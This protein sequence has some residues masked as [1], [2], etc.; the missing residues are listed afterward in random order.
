MKKLLLAMTAIASLAFISKAATLE[1][2]TGTSFESF[3]VDTALDISADDN[4][5]PN[6]TKYWLY[7]GA[8]GTEETPVDTGCVIKTVDYTDAETGYA[9]TKPAIAP[10]TDVKALGIEADKRL[11]RTIT[12]VNGNPV[13]IGSGI[14]FDTMVQFTA[15][16]TAPTP[17][18][19]DK[20]IV[21]L[22]G[23]DDAE[24]LFGATTGLVVTAGYL[25]SVEN[26][27]ISTNYFV[28]T[29]IE[30]N[31]WHRL[32][33]K[34]LDKISNES[35]SAPAGFVV[36]I[37]EVAVTSTEAKGVADSAVASLT[38]TA[39]K[40]AGTNQL[41]PSLVKGGATAASTLTAVDIEGT[42]MIDNISFTSVAPNFAVDNPTLVINWGDGITSVTYKIGEADAVTATSG[43]EITLEKASSEVTINA[44][45]ASGYVRGTWLLNGVATELATFTISAPT[46]IE[47]VAKAELIQV[48]D[49]TFGSAADL[50]T[51]LNK[52]ASYIG[53]VQLLGDLKIGHDVSEGEG[54][55]DLISVAEGSDITLDLAGKTITL[56]NASASA[57]VANLGG[58][59]TI[60]NSTEAIGRI[61]AQVG[62]EET[63]AY[64]VF[65]A[66]GTTTIAGGIFDGTVIVGAPDGEGGVIDTGATL[67]I[68]GGSF[69]STDSV[70]FYLT[71]YVNT[72]EGYNCTYADG[73]W[74]VASASTPEPGPEPTTYT[75]TIP[76]VANA[77]A[78]V[79]N[80]EGAQ[81]ANLSA[82]AAGTVVTVTWTAAE[83]CKITAG[84][85][86]QITMDGNK[87][88]A[89]PTVEAIQYATVMITPVD[90]CTITVKNGN[91]DVATGAKFD[92][93]NKVKLTVTRTPAA[94]Y[95]LD[96]CAPEQV[97]C[98][99]AEN[100]YEITAAVKP[101]YPNYIPEN[102]TADTKLKFDEWVTNKAN[103]DRDTA[104][105]NME[106]FLLNVAPNAAAVAAE[107]A[108]FKVTAITVNAD[109]S[110][111]VTTTTT[112]SRKEL[113]NGT[114]KVK[115]KVNL[116]DSEWL[117]KDDTQHRFFK[118][119]LEVQ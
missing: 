67:S 101:V 68:T 50:A 80:S 33:I 108:N 45:Y 114:V 97:L 111:T 52:Q 18:A 115:G 21:W 65:C 70:N 91:A 113:Y 72:A 103:D 5:V 61:V 66:A 89:T 83:D 31:S 104:S 87:E 20:L 1:G 7:D 6:G 75:L 43:Q 94:G 96:N 42:G 99:D 69:A 106:A 58:T 100:T 102:A 71:N 12:G 10:E 109:G 40:W 26:D 84:A 82:I 119:F 15:T 32:T 37:D 98:L 74:T 46:V 22:Y 107:K 93:D 16:D 62:T 54:A 19:N 88:A 49:N 25:N 64:A 38:P 76:E 13:D 85:T 34:A 59:L 8:P 55:Y 63:P 44:V 112:N 110:V 41:F 73:Y 17:G 53:T 35:A 56:T 29:T 105:A 23:S 39:A 60:T 48:G 95:V 2:P 79:T 78:V 24:A 116:T 36:F 30:P 51:W 118:A 3:D 9:G 86:E 90:N 28:G 27:I 11:T 47:L 81:I 117:P 92:I 4:G 14:Y 77:T 57:A